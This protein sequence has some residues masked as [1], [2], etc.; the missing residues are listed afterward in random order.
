MDWYPW[1]EEAVKRAKVLDRPIFL[2]IG[3]ATCKWCHK[4]EEESFSEESVA[5][6]MNEAF[7]NVK[8]DKE[9]NPELDNLYMEF[10]QALMSTGGGWPLNVLLTPDL[11]PFFALT[12]L[13][14]K[15]EEGRLGMNEL[16]SHIQEMW[17]SEE[18]S[19]IEAQADEIVGLMEEAVHEKSPSLPTGDELKR[20]FIDYLET[21]DPVN[22]GIKGKPKFPLAYHLNYLLEASLAYEDPRGLFF[23]EKTCEQILRGEIYDSAKGGL[24]RYASGEAWDHPHSEKMLY[25]NALFLNALAALYSATKKEEYREYAE[26]H[27]DFIFREMRSDEG[28]FY[29]SVAASVDDK[30]LTSWNGLMIEALF[31]AGEAF[32]KPE[33]LDAAKKGMN[34]IREKLWDGQRLKKRWREGSADFAGGIDDYAM[35][36]SALIAL[37]DLDWA[38][39]LA[40]ILKREFKEEGGAFFST[41]GEAMMLMRRCEIYDGAMPSG[42]GMHALNLVRLA[43]AVGDETYIQDAEEIIKVIAP[44]ME[45]YPPGVVQTMRA[46]LIYLHDNPK[47]L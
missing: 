22:G 6:K 12:Y 18:K 41:N 33:L 29:S 24:S 32:D 1:G 5:A 7:V 16:V 35:V 39:E 45:A 42:N 23:A 38:K 13:P 4:M 15:K 2:S 14:A 8:V 34:F 43:K 28:A 10:A 36:I 3:Y 21:C 11:K 37:G 40:E 26:L 30:I 31:V 20:A 9:E 44:F 47:T 25:D 17:E 19:L 27:I 46:Q